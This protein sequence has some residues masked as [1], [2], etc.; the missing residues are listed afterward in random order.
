MN[1]MKPKLHQDDWRGL[2]VYDVIGRKFHLTIRQMRHST[3]SPWMLVWDLLAVAILVLSNVHSYRD[4][5]SIPLAAVFWIIMILTITVFYLLILYLGM[6][7]SKR[8][9]GF[10][11]YFPVVGFIAMTITTFLSNFNYSLMSGEAY[12]F[13]LA[14]SHLLF[15]IALGFLFETLFMIFVYPVVL[16]DFDNDEV[17]DTVPI[18]RSVTI[19]GTPFMSDEIRSV[20]SQDH[21][22]EVATKTSKTLL[23]ARLADVVAQLSGDD[24]IMPHRSYWV[25]R[26]AVSQMTGN[27]NKKALILDTGDE[28]PIARGRVAEVQV[29]LENKKL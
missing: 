25:A 5:L 26:S 27:A 9:S 11:I 29:W 24:G 16:A 4:T 21:Y 23:R 7:I 28:V 13:E 20:S 1:K 18:A 15:N 14:S 10:F 3:P 12:T 6:L 2:P 22:V 19:A 17:E 8:F